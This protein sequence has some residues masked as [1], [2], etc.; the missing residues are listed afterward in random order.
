M[1]ASARVLG[2]VGWDPRGNRDESVSAHEITQRH[3]GGL[4]DADARGHGN[5]SRAVGVIADPETG[6]WRY[7][8]T[9]VMVRAGDAESLAKAARTTSEFGPVSWTLKFDVSSLRHL[10]DS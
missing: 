10:F 3:G 8:I 5:A 1:S 2:S 9:A 4:R 7:E 6:G